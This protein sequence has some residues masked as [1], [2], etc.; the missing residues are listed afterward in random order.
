[1]TG[2][3]SKCSTRLKIYTLT[4]HDALPIL[5]FCKTHTH[6]P[7]S[8]SMVVD[9]VA[10]GGCSERGN[11]AGVG[12]GMGSRCGEVMY[13]VRIGS[14]HTHKQ[15]H[16]TL[17][18]CNFRVAHDRLPF[19]VQHQVEDIHSHPT[20]RSS[21][22]NILQNTHAHTGQLQYGGGYSGGRRMQRVRKR[23]GRRLRYGQ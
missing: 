21:D 3:R 13:T 1:M 12:Y 17:F 18:F 7:G 9:T 14:T 2:F 19:E 6:T 20:R 16:A 8:Y 4:L 10:G 15:T 23:C 22:L 11:G 5:I